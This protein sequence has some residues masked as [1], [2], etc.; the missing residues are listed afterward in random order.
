[1][2]S[3]NNLG[4]GF[5]QKLALALQSDQYVRSICLKKNKVGIE[6]VK[7]LAEAAV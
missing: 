2:L 6:G 5:T 7:T 4:D 3:R 1:M